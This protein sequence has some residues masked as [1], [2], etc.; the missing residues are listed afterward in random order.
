MTLPGVH[1]LTGYM[2]VNLDMAHLT[3]LCIALELLLNMHWDSVDDMRSRW[4]LMLVRNQYVKLTLFSFVEMYPKFLI[5]KLLVTHTSK[6]GDAIGS[7]EIYTMWYEHFRSLYNTV[8]D[9]AS[10]DI[11][12]SACD[13]VSDTCSTVHVTVNEVI[14]S[15]RVQKRRKSPG[16]NGLCMES[17]VYSGMRLCVHLSLLFTL[18]IRHCFLPSS[19]MDITIVP[20]VKTNLVTWPTWIAIVQSHCQ[21][22]WPRY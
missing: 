11:F 21:M 4:K 12:G 22:L 18:C 10:R 13:A 3:N 20:L 7:D 8:S 14:D 16:P 17:Y 1:S 2:R 5:R 19:F 6:I 9:N 15:I